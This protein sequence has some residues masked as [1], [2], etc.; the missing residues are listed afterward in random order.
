MVN[1]HP[2]KFGDHKNCGNKDVLICHAISLDHE[3]QGPCYF[4]GRS[5]LRKFPTLPG[6]L[7]IGNRDI[8]VLVCLVTF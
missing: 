3:T 2:D 7:V 4:I 6:L 1:E 5:P 8:T